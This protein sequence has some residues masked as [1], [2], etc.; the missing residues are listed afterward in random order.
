MRRKMILNE[1]VVA[2]ITHI[3]VLMKEISNKVHTQQ[4]MYNIPNKI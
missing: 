4:S 1:N 3:I 2:A